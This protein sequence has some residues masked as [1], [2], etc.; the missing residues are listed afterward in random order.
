[1]SARP[2]A[3]TLHGSPSGPAAADFWSARLLQVAAGLRR[4]SLALT[5]PSGAS[6]RFVGDEPGPAA[7]LRLQRPRAAR[8]LLLGG[9]IAFAEAYRDGDW[10]SPDLVGLLRL[11]AANEPALG[12]LGQGLA[13]LRA[14]QR[15]WHRL[16]AN[17]RRGSRRNIAFHYDL[18]NDF[19]ARWLDPGL[20]YSSALFTAPDQ[21]LEAA[22][23]AKY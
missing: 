23:A 16:H 8:R 17:S 14:T 15:L 22:Q 21:S 18:G 13:A 11:A 3:G 19:Y 6:R 12:G 20:T 9:A 10:D 4:G 1:M 5:L 2:D 7:G